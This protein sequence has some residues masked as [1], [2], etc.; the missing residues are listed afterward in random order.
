[1]HSGNIGVIED[2][3]SQ[4]NIIEKRG[5]VYSAEKEKERK[6]EPLSRCNSNNKP[7]HFVT[8]FSSSFSL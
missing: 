8:F 6:R 5:S 7:F 4:K 2:F 1:M 3:V